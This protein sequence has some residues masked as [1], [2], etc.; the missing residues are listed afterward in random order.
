MK[1]T[2]LGLFCAALFVL[3]GRLVSDGHSDSDSQRGFVVTLFSD[4]GLS[5]MYLINQ[6]KQKACALLNV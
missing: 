2:C 4:L 6:C 5:A 3:T 1:A